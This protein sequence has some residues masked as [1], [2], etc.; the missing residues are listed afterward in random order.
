MCQ[1]CELKFK[2]ATDHFDESLATYR[3][4]CEE[5]SVRDTPA[6]RVVDLALTFA[7]TPEAT[8]FAVW[9]TAIAFERLIALEQAGIL[10]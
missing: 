4:E 2:Y 8:N 9:Y 6:E 3:R 5:G 7:E 10:T 1:K